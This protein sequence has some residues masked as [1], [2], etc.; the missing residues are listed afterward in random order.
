MEEDRGSRGQLDAARRGGG[1]P[2]IPA[3]VLLFVDVEK[4]VLATPEGKRAAI[5]LED[6]RA[7]ADEELHK[8]EME[9]AS[10]RRKLEKDPTA[11]G[12][13]QTKAGEYEAM[14]KEK[15]AALEAAQDRRF[16]PIVSQ[17]DARMA[18]S[19]ERRVGKEGS[20]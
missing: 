14:V 15:Q 9:I 10:V 18:R 11:R 12:E 2:L 19:E 17:I 1:A 20:S 8:K 5:E 6:A 13:Y 16:E 3:I 7:R 4:A